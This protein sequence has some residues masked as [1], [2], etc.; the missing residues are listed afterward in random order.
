MSTQLRRPLKVERAAAEMRLVFE[1]NP[2]VRMTR[3][4]VEECLDLEGFSPSTRQRALWLLAFEGVIE[5]TSTYPPEGP[6]PNIYW[7]SEAR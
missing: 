3:R 2:G 4:D 1:Q 7:K 5:H 6:E